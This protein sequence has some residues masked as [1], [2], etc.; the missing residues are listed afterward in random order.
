MTIPGVLTGLFTRKFPYHIGLQPVKSG[1]SISTGSSD[2]LQF[3]GVAIA[4]P[5]FS[6]GS[7]QERKSRDQDRLIIPL[8][9]DNHGIPVIEFR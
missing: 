5:R 2:T 6:P 9:A 7:L 3:H 1:Y 4:L 8:K